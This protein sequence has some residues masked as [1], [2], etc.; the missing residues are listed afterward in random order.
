[1]NLESWLAL[2]ALV[3]I[4][5]DWLLVTISKMAVRAKLHRIGFLFPL[6]L[7]PFVASMFLAFHPIEAMPDQAN[8]R[9]TSCISSGN[10][11][12]GQSTGSNLGGIR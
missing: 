4:T 3:F 6:L 11:L 8:K 7:A 12:F 5:A 1:M 10:D 2:F 9:T